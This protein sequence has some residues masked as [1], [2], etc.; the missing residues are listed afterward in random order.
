MAWYIGKRWCRFVASNDPMQVS[1]NFCN[2]LN[3]PKVK[4]KMLRP[5]LS[6][7]TQVGIA[8]LKQLCEYKVSQ[9]NQEGEQQYVSGTGVSSIS[10]CLLSDRYKNLLLLDNLLTTFFNSSR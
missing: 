3:V 4:A 1:S 6:T 9:Q 8:W 10:K 5:I 7:G 2:E